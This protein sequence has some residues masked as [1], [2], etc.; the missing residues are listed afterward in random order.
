[1]TGRASISE[2]EELEALGHRTWPALEDEM[3][4][5]WLVRAAHGVSRRS[6]SVNPL[7]P[8]S[9]TLDE[10]IDATIA[11]LEARNQ[12]PVFRLNPRS[13]FG[14]EALLL[15]R[16]LVRHEG[17]TIMTTEISSDSIPKQVEISSSR[18][19]EWTDVLLDRDPPTRHVVEQLLDSHT[20]PTVFALI[21]VEGQAVA[22][23]MA[24]VYDA[25]AAI[26]NMRTDDAHRRHG[27]ARTML[28]GILSAAYRQGAR[29]G[30][31]QVMGSNTAAVGLYVS[32]GFLSRYELLVPS[33]AH[34][35]GHVI[36]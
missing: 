13:P 31:L 15:A 21:R 18:T 10:A 8:P 35:V 11:W 36:P 19:A 5:G 14:L 6:N 33:A 34:R 29:Q 30:F 27:H 23:G 24:V 28:K 1:M 9:G 3:I 12:P 7:G 25:D 20:A 26:F 16:G 32:Y 2:I 17:A 4:C 22:I